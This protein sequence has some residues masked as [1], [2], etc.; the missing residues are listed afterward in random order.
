MNQTISVGGSE[1]QQD[2][3]KSTNNFS[4]FRDNNIFNRSD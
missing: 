4:Q 1:Q 2:T 3:H